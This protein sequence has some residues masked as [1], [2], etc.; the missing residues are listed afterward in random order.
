[1]NNII[2]F[3]TESNGKVTK[4]GAPMNQVQ[5]FPR[6]TQ[7]AYQVYTRSGELLK[8]VESIIKPDGWT[9]PTVEEQIAKGEKNPN[10]FVENNMSTERCE[11]EGKPFMEVINNDFLND[12][13]SCSVMVAHNV[14]FDKPVLGAEFIRYSVKPLT[15]D[16]KI[17][18]LCTMKLSTKYCNLPGKYG[19]KWPSLVELHQKLFH[20]DFSGN[21][22]A[23][24][25]VEACAKS[26][27]KL[28]ELGIIV[29]P[30]EL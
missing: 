4:W 16:K 13:D 19:A 15:P 3:D 6:I 8:S 14:A 27:F 23:M 20:E 17:S 21:H 29:L 1:M 9:I 7:L 25:D 2:V 5:Y 10:F 12:F 11:K 22:D 24:V 18:W 26:F 30:E 28:V